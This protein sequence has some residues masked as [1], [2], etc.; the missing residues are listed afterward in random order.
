MIIIIIM[1]IIIF[2]DFIAHSKFWCES[3]T[4]KIIDYLHIIYLF[5]YYD[6]FTYCKLTNMETKA[7]SLCKCPSL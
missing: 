6:L 3:N 4:I 2:F 5:I 7:W 1:I